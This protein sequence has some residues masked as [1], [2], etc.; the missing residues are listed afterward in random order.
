MNTSEDT[1][2]IRYINIK[3]E[4]IH[5][6]GKFAIQWNIFEY[7]KCNYNSNCER[8]INM[9]N[10]FENLDK[11]PFILLAQ[12]FKKRASNL[13]CS[14]EN[15]VKNYI[16]P[17]ENANIN[18]ND[19]EKHMPYVIDFIES[20]GE[21]NLAGALLAIYRIRNNMFHGLKGYGELDDQIELFKAMNAV[22]KEVII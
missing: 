13:V 4:T 9:E 5:E 20:N 2:Q 21:I 1:T 6:I 19:I 16:Y 10:T 14:I 18:N 12:I 7:L 3:N 15:Y 17:K 8:I 22:L 11:Q